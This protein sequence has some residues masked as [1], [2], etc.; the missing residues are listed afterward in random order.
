[1]KINAAIASYLVVI[2]IDAMPRVINLLMFYYESTSEFLYS[3]LSI[4]GAVKI[5]A[6]AGW[7]SF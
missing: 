1:M 2:L 5:K 3:Y 7:L 6:Q 4:S